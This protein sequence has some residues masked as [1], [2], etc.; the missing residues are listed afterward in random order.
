MQL[1][2]YIWQ[3]K[4]SFH[5]PGFAFGVFET[6]ADNHINSRKHYMRATTLRLPQRPNNKNNGCSK[7]WIAKLWFFLKKKIDR[8]ILHDNIGP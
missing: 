1:G 2:G 8:I 3:I 6:V 7:W 4:I 5:I